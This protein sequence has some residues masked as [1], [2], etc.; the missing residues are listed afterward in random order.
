MHSAIASL[1]NI[2]RVDFDSC[3]VKLFSGNY[4]SHHGSSPIDRR[5]SLEYA[6]APHS[7]T[8]HIHEPPY[9]STS[10]IHEPP[11]TASVHEPSRREPY[12]YTSGSYHSHHS[13]LVLLSLNL[14]ISFYK[15]FYMNCFLMIG[16]I[17]RRLMQGMYH[18]H[19]MHL[20]LGMFMNRGMDLMF[21]NLFTCQI[22][23][24]IIYFLLDFFFKKGTVC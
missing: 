2:S 7:Y 23:N 1:L 16:C 4:H 10:S 19:T 11:Y 22:I 12:T 17:Y 9:A 20:A 6:Y 5:L 21:L 8:R 14:F 3:L 18:L 24:Y 13:D 15:L